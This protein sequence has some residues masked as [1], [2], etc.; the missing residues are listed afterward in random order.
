MQTDLEIIHGS[1][2]A[3]AAYVLIACDHN[4]GPVTVLAR[5]KDAK[6]AFINLGPYVFHS[7][8]RDIDIE[9][10]M[11]TAEAWSARFGADIYF[12]RRL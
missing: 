1:P 11:Q 2:P 8:Q 12:Q 7:A 10:A 4:D 5:V 3:N 6:H 9:T